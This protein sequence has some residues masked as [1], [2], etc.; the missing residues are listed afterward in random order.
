ML[1]RG[2]GL[3]VNAGKTYWNNVHVHD[4]SNLYLKLVEEAAAGGSTSEWEGKRPVWGAEGY[5]FC[6]SGE[7]V[8]GE[9]SQWIVTEAHKQ[10]L[11]KTNEVKSLS[12][13][14][15][16]ECTPHGSAMWG[17]NSRAHAKRARELLRWQPKAPGLRECIKPAVDLE[18]KKLGMKP[19]HAKIAA[20]EA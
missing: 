19:G 16:D 18:A 12:K 13:E 11:L 2:Y 10:E 15:A 20:G 1:E 14:E 3:R 7:H 6:E 17:C 8:W 5:Y 9:V 4:L